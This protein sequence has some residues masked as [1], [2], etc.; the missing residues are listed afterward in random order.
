MV[1]EGHSSPSL[2]LSGV[3]GEASRRT[4]INSLLT[5]LSHMRDRAPKNDVIAVV[6]AHYSDED[7]AA[8]RDLCFSAVPPIQGSK[9]RRRACRAAKDNVSV[10]L[11]VLHEAPLGNL[12]LF[13]CS[14][15]TDMP[16]RDIGTIDNVALYHAYQALRGEVR[17]LN[18]KIHHLTEVNKSLARRVSKTPYREGRVNMPGGDGDRRYDGGSRR[19]GGGP[20]LDCSSPSSTGN[21]SGSRQGTY[22]IPP[23][24]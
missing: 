7:V 4:V 12:P 3:A 19:S 24:S 14:D 16:P 8:A 13:V 5:Y 23:P 9:V 1:R 6:C 10:I 21:C 22:H 20:G 17:I 2:P 11:D 15:I 18:K